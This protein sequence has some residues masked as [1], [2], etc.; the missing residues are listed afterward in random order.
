MYI[1][2][3]GE[4][5]F[6]WDPLK[7]ARN[8]RKHGVTFSEPQTVFSDEH[9]LLLDD[10]GLASDDQRFV[11][12]GLSSALRLLVVV[13]TYRDVDRTIRLIS[14]RKPTRS[15]RVQYNARFRR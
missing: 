1:S 10:L 3:A 6:E 4:F 7:A 15:E 12:L 5:R 9:G 14:A 11:L 13:H 2:S 8:V